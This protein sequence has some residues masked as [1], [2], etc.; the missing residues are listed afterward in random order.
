LCGMTTAGGGSSTPTDAIEI[1]SPYSFS[2][3]R[4]G[5]R[6]H[7]GGIPRGRKR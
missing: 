3:S 2:H 7:I 1:P 6:S 5:N 4:P